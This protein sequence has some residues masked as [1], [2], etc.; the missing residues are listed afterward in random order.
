MM[1][2]SRS[3]QDSAKPSRRATSTRF[4]LACLAFVACVDAATGVEAPSPPPRIPEFEFSASIYGSNW[5]ASE[6]TVT[7]LDNNTIE[8]AG[9]SREGPWADAIVTLRLVGVTQPALRS[10]AVDGDGSIF[11]I[12]KAPNVWDTHTFAGAGNAVIGLLNESVLAGDFEGQADGPGGS[13]EVLFIAH[14]RFRV[15]L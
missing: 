2:T 14:G 5:R 12:T 4:V 8:I 6:I 10:L 1:K 11:S 7:R 9:V 13:G 15:R 3:Q